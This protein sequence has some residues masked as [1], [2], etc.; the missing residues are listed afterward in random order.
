MLDQVIAHA[1][2]RLWWNALLLQM[3][4]AATVGLFVLVLMLLLGTDVIAGPWP[5]IL[6]LSCLAAGT[7]MARRRLPAFSATS[8]ILDRKLKLPDTLATAL[9]FSDAKRKCAEEFRAA[10]K[11][12]AQEIAQRVNLRE[13]IPVKTPRAVFLPAALAIAATCLFVVRYQSAAH[14]DLREPM[15]GVLRQLVEN[16]RV[17]VAKIV[18][19][20]KLSKIAELMKSEQSKKGGEG[21][22]GEGSADKPAGNGEATSGDKGTAVASEQEK[23]KP[24][25]FAGEQEESQQGEAKQGDSLAGNSQSGASRNGQGQREAEGSQQQQQGAGSQS[26]SAASGS[27]MV[28]KMKDTLANLLSALKPPSGG[29][30]GQQAMNGQDGKSG[31]KN[32]KQGATD[33]GDASGEKGEGESSKP[34]NAMAGGAGPAGKSQADKLQ[35][36][37]AGRDEGSKEIRVAEQLQAMGKLD[38]VFGK[39]AEDVTGEFTVEAPP[40]PQNLKTAYANRSAEHS[41]VEATGIRDEV[42]VAYQDYVQHYYDLLR[43]AEGSSRREGRVMAATTRRSRTVR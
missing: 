39:R 29:A 16:A 11:A 30:G 3:I 4:V 1:R 12:Q 5:V 17:E 23:P 15:G 13:V 2:R 28:N 38:R 21:S 9:F 32:Q 19:E 22:D 41:E 27:G 25:S 10:Q 34:G 7:W 35:G 18:D 43:Q 26:A 33:A 6:P 24:D 37:G 14:L 31:G 36:T 8:E 42:P 20:M 40:G